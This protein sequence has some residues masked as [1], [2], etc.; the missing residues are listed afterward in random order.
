MKRAKGVIISYKASDKLIEYLKK[1]DLEIINTKSNHFVY[2]S[3]SDH[4]DVFIFQT[5]EGLIVDPRYYEYFNGKLEKYNCHVKKGK[6][7]IGFSYPENVYYNAIGINGILI[8][9]K[10]TDKS[11]DEMFSSKII[12]KQG[13]AKCSILPVD[14]NS[15][16]TSDEGIYKITKD[17]FDVLLI[18]PKGILLDQMDHGFIGGA[19]GKIS[20]DE[21]FFTGNIEKHSD[22]EAIYKFVSERKIKLQYPKDIPLTDLGSVMFFD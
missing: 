17:I 21:I 19:G 14:E 20:E 4:P 15:F 6:S 22:Y 11:I 16:I 3:I 9:S 5:D 8:G 7:I 1:L 12:V 2:E 13:Y 18:T 10:Y